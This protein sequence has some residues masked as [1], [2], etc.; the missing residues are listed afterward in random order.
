MTDRDGLL[1]RAAA[2]TYLAEQVAKEQL[3]VRVEL[4]QTM[5]PGERA[6]AALADGTEVGGVT[7]GRPAVSAS[8]V[9]ADEFMRWVENDHPDEIVG[10]VRESF[11]A[12]VLAECKK[13]GAAVTRHGE[14]VPGVRVG[15]G[16][17]SYR[18]SYNEE[19][20][21]EFLD[22]IRANRDLLLSSMPLELGPR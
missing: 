16:S 22:A 13:A 19:H 15:Y 17:A 21:P 10:T 1:V 18:P 6:V 9:N 3:A 14:V 5:K 11:K 2:L 8:V 12:A 20:L 4:M 7:V